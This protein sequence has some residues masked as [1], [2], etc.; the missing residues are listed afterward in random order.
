MMMR[1]RFSVFS[2]SPWLN[3][4]RAESTTEARRTLRR[5]VFV[6]LLLL[7]VSAE[8]STM[9]QKRKTVV[10]LIVRGGTVV[11]MDGSRRVI[12]NGA[13]AVK[14]GRIVAVGRTAELERNY[15]AREI[16][17]AGGK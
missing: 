15:S 10:D 13:V 11:T 8:S 7:S 3:N 9:A 12:E 16:V 4:P 14:A 17:N 1:G 2:V 6:L 5:L